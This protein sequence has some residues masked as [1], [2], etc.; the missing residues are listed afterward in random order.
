MPI[1]T[2]FTTNPV[3]NKSNDD[4]VPFIPTSDLG[5]FNYSLENKTIQQPPTPYD[6]IHPFNHV[7]ESECGHL[8][9]DR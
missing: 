7:Y 9:R 1:V 3:I 5:S 6:A 2:E 4:G 8:G